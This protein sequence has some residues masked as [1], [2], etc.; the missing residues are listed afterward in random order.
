LLTVTPRA[1]ATLPTASNTESQTAPVATSL[2][3]ASGGGPAAC[4]ALPERI[5]ME[6][7]ANL[8][9]ASTPRTSRQITAAMTNR[10]TFDRR[11][12]PES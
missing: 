3:I 9:P 1:A 5:S 2:P 10:L 12:P 11:C 6:I 8:V 4:A 7:C